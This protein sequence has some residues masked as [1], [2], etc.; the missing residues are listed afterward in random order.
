MPNIT[1][2]IYDGA[3]KLIKGEV[4]LHFRQGMKNLLSAFVNGGSL[5]VDLQQYD[6][7]QALAVVASRSKYQ[8]CGQLLKP[9]KLPEQ[10]HLML[11][12]KKERFDFEGNDQLWERL[13]ARRKSYAAFLDAIPD[14]KACALQ[15]MNSSPASLACFLNVLESIRWLPNGKDV[16]ATMKDMELRPRSPGKW[17]GVQQ[18]RIFIRS[19][20]TLISE[21]NKPPF[22]MADHRMHPEADMGR[23]ES[24]PFSEANLNFSLKTIGNV[25]ADSVLAEVDLDY[26]Q[27]VGAHFA[28]EVIPNT[29]SKWAGSRR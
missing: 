12:H 25:P 4:L 13:K 22:V 27:D 2:F 3:G 17:K 29:V 7:T 16:I 18:D 19:T 28:L 24:G 26:Y 14:A 15:L 20:S 10:L 1:I 9:D 6:T 11:V 21:L 23:K 8:Q 5:K